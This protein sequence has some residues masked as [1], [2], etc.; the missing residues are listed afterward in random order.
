M[1]TGGDGGFHVATILGADKPAVSFSHDSVAVVR[2][3]VADLDNDGEVIETLLVEFVS[4]D[5]LNPAFF[6][7]YVKQ[8]QNQNYG[9]NKVL[10]AEYSLGYEAMQAYLYNPADSVLT[11]ASLS[12]ERREKAGKAP[13]EG[14]YFCWVS[15][16]IRTGG[17]CVGDPPND[18]CGDREGRVEIT[19]VYMDIGGGGG[20]GGGS[21][22]RPEFSLACDPFVTRGG[23][24]GCTVSITSDDPTV[25]AS[26]FT[27][28]WSSGV[29]ASE[30]RSGDDGYIWMGTAT[31]TTSIT[32]VVTQGGFTT[33]GHI[34]VNARTGWGPPK[35]NAATQHTTQPM[36]IPGRLGFYGIG[37]DVSP[38][39]IVKT[40]SGPWAGN[41]MIDKI[42]ALSSELHISTMH[43]MGQRI[44]PQTLLALARLY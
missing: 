43:A 34:T 28:Q 25:T 23:V 36:T 44:L 40:G 4:S 29:G 22:D 2:T 8:W 5:P 12:L 13:E 1:W 31:E 3:L 11:P 37:P 6:L 32:V 41:Y 38:S 30:T 19:C 21:G 9:E 10:A 14:I 18:S 15:D 42:P 27:Y 7:D 33:T 35:L 39:P 20:G 16:F 26:Q 24:A 17:V